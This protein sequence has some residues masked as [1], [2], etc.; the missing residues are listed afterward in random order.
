MGG[1]TEQISGYKKAFF[2]GLIRK[3][4]DTAFIS[5]F[6]ETWFSNI[7]V[8][9]LDAKRKEDIGIAF[10]EKF[11]ELIL[12]NSKE[13]KK[14]NLNNSVSV[15]EFYLISSKSEAQ[16]SRYADLAFLDFDKNDS[17][18]ILLENK[19]FSHDSKNQ[20]K[21]YFSALNS[22]NEIKNKYIVY[23]T[24]FGD[25]PKNFKTDGSLIILSWVDDLLPILN[26][27]NDN[28]LKNA[29]ELKILINLLNW[30]K[31]VKFDK[32]DF[33]LYTSN[34]LNCV[35]EK[36]YLQTKYYLPNAIIKHINTKKSINS[37]T[38]DKKNNI[39][40]E[41]S[42]LPNISV[43]LK[44]CKANNHTKV[45]KKYI[46]PFLEDS[47]QYNNFIDLVVRNVISSFV[48]KT[49]FAERSSVDNLFKNDVLYQF[50]SYYFKQLKV[51]LQIYNLISR[52]KSIFEENSSEEFVSNEE[53]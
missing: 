24:L 46:I 39:K 22:F 18:M 16:K 36:F 4:R 28:Q 51:L 48:I 35:S 43:V 29:P 13:I 12:R 30:I 19:L 21:D 34:F 10:N 31:Q 6:N 40:L 33:G 47:G 5:K 53:M 52:K 17:L 15:R 37:I 42:V 45:L 41:F 20:I 7:L 50:T 2:P 14:F 49:D 32:S 3:Q 9:L 1:S 27:L 23:L 38:F 8:W 26:E 11:V 44:V 25:N